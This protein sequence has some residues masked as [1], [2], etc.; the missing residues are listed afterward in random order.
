MTIP[1]KGLSA[2]D[3]A[4]LARLLFK[5]GHAIRPVKSRETKTGPY[6]HAIEL[7]DIKSAA[8]GGANSEGGRTK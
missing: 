3:R 1:C 6:T 8:P 5:A 2:D 4:D 7:L